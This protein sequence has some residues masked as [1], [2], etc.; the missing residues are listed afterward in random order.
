MPFV[1]I[2]PSARS[3]STSNS[4]STATPLTGSPPS[5]VEWRSSGRV[6]V[7]EVEDVADRHRG[8]LERLVTG[9]R[10][11][12]GVTADVRPQF[13]L[14]LLAD[15]GPALVRR[16]HVAELGVGPVEFV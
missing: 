15:D 11:A 1:T 10:R 9:L 16:R 12:S 5:P 4:V 2:V 14:Q 13:R 7:A 8:D 3:N 6:R